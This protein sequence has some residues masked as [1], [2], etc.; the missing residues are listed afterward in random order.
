V[1]K[2][3]RYK[4]NATQ[5]CVH[6]MVHATKQTKFLAYQSPFVKLSQSQY[7]QLVREQ[8]SVSDWNRI[9]FALNQSNC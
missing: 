2:H 4:M 6:I 8:H 3:E 1:S 9:L 7:G 5:A